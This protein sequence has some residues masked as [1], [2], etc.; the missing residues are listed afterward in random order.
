MRTIRS[1]GSDERGA[2]GDD[3][4]WNRREALGLCVAV[5]AASVGVASTVA[6]RTPVE[7]DAGDGD[8]LDHALRLLHEQ[9]PERSQGL[10]T[11]APMVAE[12]LCVLGY[13][14]RTA[15][16]VAR[17]DAPLRRIAP[18][19]ARIDAT[20][21]RSMLGPQWHAPTWEAQL[22]RWSSWRV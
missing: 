2:S 6:A 4:T 13:A 8:A 21:W 3:A 22:E 12:T 16:W 15:E 14:D 11:H 18:P 5:A 9:A 17:D 7:V 20:N 10:S 19:S 1:I